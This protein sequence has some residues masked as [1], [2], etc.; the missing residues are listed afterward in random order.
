MEQP[1][2]TS[3]VVAYMIFGFIFTGFCLLLLFIMSMEIINISYIPEGL[4]E[5]IFTQR[6]MNN[7]ECFTYQDKDTLRI[8]PGIIDLEKFKQENLDNCYKREVYM[9]AP[10]F[11]LI[12]NDKTIRTSDFA[13]NKKISKQILIFK[14]NKFENAE[15]K[16]ESET[17]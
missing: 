10:E 6:F 2:I 8:Y 13:S 7:P 5:Y 14:D 3:K 11:R 4:E 1:P 16:I 12:I 17:K 15:L 9:Y